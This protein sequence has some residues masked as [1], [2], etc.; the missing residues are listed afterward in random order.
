MRRLLLIWT[1]ML[2]LLTPCLTMAEDTQIALPALPAVLV[3][4]E[5]VY[6]PVLT[7]DNLKDNGP[8]ILSRGGTVEE[9]QE[10][11]KT[12]GILLKAYDDKNDRLLVVTGLQDEDGQRYGDIDL[13][14]ADTRAQYR[15][16][17]LKDGP[18]A[19]LGYRVESAEWKNFKQVGRFLM[20]KYSFREGGELKYRGFARRTVKNGLSIMVDMQVYG[21]KLK[22]GDNTALN[23]VFD[24]LA[25]TGN[26]G[27]GVAM[28]VFLNESATAPAE[29]NQPTFTMSGITRSG[30]KLT[31]TVLSFSSNTPSNF[32]AQADAKGNYSLPI[33]LSGEGVYMLTLMVEAE[34]LEPL[35][36]TYSINYGRSLLPVTFTSQL[37]E[38]ITGD[39]YTISG[40][41]EPGTTVQLTVNEKSSTKRAN[42]KGVFSFPVTTKEDGSYQ[43]RV[44]FQKT[45][46][47]MRTFDFTAVRGSA[48]TVVA[49]TQTQTGTSDAAAATSGEALSPTYTDLVAKADQYDGKLLTYDG[50]ITGV[51]QQAGDFEISLALRKG[52]A[53]YADTLLAVDDQDPQLAVGSKV[54]IY[55]ILEG[56]GSGSGSTDYS[57]PK[58]RVQNITLLEEAPAAETD[59]ASI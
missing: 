34:G 18:F 14:S 15:S 6:S 21:R 42:S 55:G 46:L 3:L 47:D 32:M 24:T 39:K 45:G 11:F 56:L 57:Y 51:Q 26:V 12:K 59:G 25:F 30:A 19:A 49:S 22:A 40:V 37:P 44:S 9:W 17:Y 27:E 8:F 50:Y 48:A 35:E 1:L 33:Q 31:A 54:R 7:P 28:P 52:A 2:C 20:I 36:K 29:T 41:T 43:I 5:G 23:K 38:V 4:P 53:G 10:E 58:L 16:M 13:Q